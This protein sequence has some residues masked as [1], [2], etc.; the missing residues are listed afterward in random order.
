MLLEL[1]R[2]T[3]GPSESA[4]A[5]SFVVALPEVEFSGRVSTGLVDAVGGVVIWLR[6]VGAGAGGFA[7]VD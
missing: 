2:G 7:P 4:G 3:A 5:G 1:L 6:C